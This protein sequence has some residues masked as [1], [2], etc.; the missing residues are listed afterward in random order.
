MPAPN[1]DYARNIKSFEKL[2]VRQKWREKRLASWW[3]RWLGKIEKQPVIISEGDSWFDFPFKSI[4]DVIGVMLRKVIGLQNFGMDSKTNVMDFVSRDDDLNGIFLRLERSG[5]HADELSAQQPDKRHGVWEKK[6]P[7]LTLYTALQNKNIQKHLDVILLSAGGNDLVQAVRHGALQQYT[8][9]WQTSYD[10]DLLKA[11]ATYVVEHY[12]QAILYRDE[13][14]PNAKV[15]CHSY[16]YAC[17]V[18]SGTKVEFK[19]SD[20]S[21]L[22]KALLKFMNLEMIQK[23]LKAV[24]INVDNLGEHTMQGDSNLHETLDALGW[25]KNPDINSLSEDESQ[26]HPERAAFIKAMLDALYNEMMHLPALYKAQTGRELSGFEYLDIRHMVQKPKYWSDF[27][28]LN[29]LGYGEVSKMFV[30]KI[31]TM[32]S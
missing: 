23:P 24:G 26:V 27:I 31:K 14:T 17:Q 29:S 3:P 5:D 22:I 11:A 10:H 28:H 1:I 2:V 8:G 6:I 13:F 16:A 15:L 12:L 19:F 32:V 18:S 25:P 21:W 7:S 20:I 4:S 9:D 30:A